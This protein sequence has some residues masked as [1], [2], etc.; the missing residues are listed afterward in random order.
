MSFGISIN[1]DVG[2]VINSTSKNLAYIGTVT[3]SRVS[4]PTYRFPPAPDMYYPERFRVPK[5]TH[6]SA[7][8]NLPSNVTPIVA[9][10]PIATPLDSKFV[11]YNAGIAIEAVVY[12]GGMW[13]AYCTCGP[14]VGNCDLYVFAQHKSSTSTYG[15][16]VYDAGGDVVFSGDSHNAKYIGYQT[17]SRISTDGSSGSTLFNSVGQSAY[18]PAKDGHT[19]VLVSN[20]GG[21]KA[22]YNTVNGYLGEGVHMTPMTCSITSGGYEY[23]I[24]QWFV[25][26]AMGNTA[27]FDIIAN[28]IYSYGL[29]AQWLPESVTRPISYISLY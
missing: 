19:N 21:T 25:S 3:L 5:F 8:I 26:S 22:F 24:T 1:N 28:S 2:T 29:G 18:I 6:K 15:I 14:L 12:E 23:Y 17:F 10:R 11:T 7:P 4:G 20:F 13:Y 16:Y 9:F 27:T